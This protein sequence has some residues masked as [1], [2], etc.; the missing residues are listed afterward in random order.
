MLADVIANFAAGESPSELALRTQLQATPPIV[1]FTQW[2]NE[3]CDDWS[4]QNTADVYA[5]SLIM[6]W[7][8][9][10]RDATR[11]STAVDEAVREDVRAGMA[12]AP[13]LWRASDAVQ[14]ELAERIA[15]WTAL[16]A[17][18]FNWTVQQGAAL[19]PN[20]ATVEEFRERLIELGQSR[21]LFGVDLS[22]V[23]LTRE[24]IVPR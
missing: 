17:G 21:H 22:A 3:S 1:P 2:F 18:Q 12:S 4:L 8:V 13:T 20:L 15:S 23:K 7:V 16:L 11:T 19:P 6:L 14:Q 5:A 24:G 10:D 9:I